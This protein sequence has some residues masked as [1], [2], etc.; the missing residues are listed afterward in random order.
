MDI[1]SLA[2]PEHPSTEERPCACIDG[3]VYVGHMVEEDGEEV[4]V[5]EAVTCKRCRV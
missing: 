4:E 5:T 1:R 2:H 3:T